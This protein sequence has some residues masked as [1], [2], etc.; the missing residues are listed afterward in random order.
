MDEL[1]NSTTG[2]S[3][4]QAQSQLNQI[5]QEFNPSQAEADGAKLAE[6][7]D[8][9]LLLLTTQLK[10]QDPTEP[11]DTNEFTNQLV[12][13]SSVE[14]AIATNE[15]L[16][17]LVNL[18]S[19]QAL[20]SAVGYVGQ[21]VDAEGNAGQL[22]EDGFANFAYELDIPANTVQIIITDS[23]GRAVFSGQGPNEA[24][25]QRVVWDG[26]NSF[27]G[28][29]EAPGTYNI[30]IT[31][32]NASGETIENQFRTFTTGPVTGA[33]VIDGEV[34]LNVAGTNVPLSNV[35]AI[36]QPVQVA[37]GTNVATDEPEEET[38]IIDDVVDAAT[39]IIDEI[40]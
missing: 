37:T 40:I 35:T 20:S 28:Q 38:T 5:Q 9:F 22:N 7:F 12:Q 25:K 33:E 36:R 26:I 31:P 11:L 32:T 27:T 19:S 34:I 1:L 16:E 3:T 24:G 8:T 39:D 10:N 17:Q 29:Q 6:D 21:F 18:Q 15:N 30:F 2:I 4:A 14:Q 13:F 23:L